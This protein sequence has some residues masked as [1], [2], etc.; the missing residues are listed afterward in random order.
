MLLLPRY[1]T[2]IRG[3]WYLGALGLRYPQCMCAYGTSEPWV[4]GSLRSYDSIGTWVYGTL[5]S[6]DS[7]GIEVEEKQIRGRGI[8]ARYTAGIRGAWYSGILGS[9]YP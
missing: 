2:G 7:I 9:R 6:S 1:T 5:R 4:Y 3:V 8:Y